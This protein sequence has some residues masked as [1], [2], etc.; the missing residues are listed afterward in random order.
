[1]STQTT[2]RTIPWRRTPLP[3]EKLKSLNERSD[4]KA[5]IQAGGYLG[6]LLVTGSLSYLAWSMQNWW[7]LGAFLFLH[8]TVAAFCIN[9]VHELVHG[10]VFKTPWLN[11]AFAYIFAFIGWIN[12][13]FFWLS[14]TEHHK[15]TLHA[16]D[17]LEVVVPIKQT[18]DGW[19]KGAFISL[20]SWQVFWNMIRYASGQLKG[21]WAH[22]LL[23][24]EAKKK[25]AYVFNWARMVVGGH[26]LIAVVSI[27]TGNWIIPVIVSLT[28]A[29]GG[30]LFL[31][32][33]N[34]QHV[35]LNEDVND[36]RLNSRTIYLHPVVEFLYWRMNYHIE[37]HMYAAV[38][39]YN[40]PKLHD[41]I[42]H[43]LPRT[44][45]GLI[46]TW[47]EIGYIMLQQKRDPNYRFVPELPGDDTEAEKVKA[48]LKAFKD[49]N[50]KEARG[51]D[52][53]PVGDGP[54]RKWE[55]QICGFIYD[56][57]RG[58][59]EEGIAPGTPWEEIPEDWCCPDCGVAKAEFDMVELV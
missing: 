21:E 41:A 15:Y 7:L 38:P 24:E 37:H 59:P 19:F 17:D 23:P 40:L 1:M 8:G 49:E 16:P 45:N 5:W 52:T 33:N 22:I 10:T 13:R 43:E 58:L 4:G 27:A 34:T 32:C 54:G 56:E 20:Y 12:H 46:E 30:W 2:D 3:A 48:R 28:P 42:K 6:L 44:P 50:E 57:A 53:I 36:F 25:R 39:C 47:I 14:H 11:T 9:G 35:G 29:Y 51:A 18:L 26:L 31:L 55:C